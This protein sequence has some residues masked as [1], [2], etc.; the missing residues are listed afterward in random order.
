MSLQLAEQYEDNEQYEQ[1]FEEYKKALAKSP[2]DLGVMERLGHLAMMLGRKSDAADYYNKIL[3]LDATNV[4]AYEQLMDIY[5]DIDR[6]KYYVSR[7]N[8]NSIDQKLEHAVNDY[9]KA[10]SRAQEDAQIIPVRFVLSALYE[11][12]GQN[13]KAVDELLKI[14]DYEDV[15]EA[16][17]LNLANLYLKENADG[18]AVE[19]LERARAQG[20][21]T[22]K[23][24]ESLAQLY[25][26]VGN[27]QA[28]ME[29]TADELTKIR[30]LLDS[31]SEQDNGA[32]K[33]AWDLIKKNEKKYK[34]DGKFLSLKAQYYYETGDNDKALTA[35]GE[36]EKFEKN[37]PLAYQMRALIYENLNDDFNAHVNWARYNLLRGN[38]DIAI[39]EFLEA[40]RLDDTNADLVASLASLYEEAG[41][42]TYALEF[43]E[44]LAKLEP[45]NKTA[46]EKLLQL[47][48][49][50]EGFI[51]K[52]VKFFNKPKLSA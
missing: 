31:A 27:S 24:R 15:N 40:Y 38:K 22:E 46:Q 6:Y 12:L 7:A 10:L 21:D 14:L 4:M 39:N 52:I 17:Y 13:M 30:A 9:K 25:L 11:Q 48:E 32:L 29:I 8:R 33:K 44:K 2:R 5:A 18:N 20:F 47:H 26:R 35:V 42:K 36:F 50:S 23:V 16:V 41:E 51:D 49:T 34:H 28:A 1:A 43:Y 37:S 3:E 45:D 19:V